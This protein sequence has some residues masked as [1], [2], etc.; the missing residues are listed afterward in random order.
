MPEERIVTPYEGTGSRAWEEGAAIPAPLEPHTTRV[1]PKWVDYNGHMSESCF[2]LVFGDSSDAFFRYLGIGEEYRA[3]GRSLFT[4]ET[5]LHHLREAAE[6][7]P[8]AL[9]LRVLGHDAKRVHVFHE[10]RHAGSGQLLAT[11]EQLLLH[12]DMEEGRAR[13]LP[14]ELTRRLDAIR[15]AHSR[16]P[17]PESVG[18]PMGIPHRPRTPAASGPGTPGAPDA[19]GTAGAPDTPGTSDTPG[20]PR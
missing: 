10:M 4:V 12:V 13:P 20:T 3:S 9:T 7:D 5:H 17:V 6:G 16:L 14:D 15:R 2:L 18:R 19:P 11:A 8:L 1:S